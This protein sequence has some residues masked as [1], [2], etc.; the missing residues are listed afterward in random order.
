MAKLVRHQKK[1]LENYFDDSDTVTD[2][3]ILYMTYDVILIINHEL[4]QLV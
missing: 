1:F 2:H 3:H 4:E